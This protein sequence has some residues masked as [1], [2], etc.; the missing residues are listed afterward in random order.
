MSDFAV[1]A[2]GGARLGLL[3]C[4]DSIQWLEHYADA[5]EVKAVAQATPQNIELT[6]PGNRIY[7]PE[8]G[9][10][11]TIVAQKIEDTGRSASV[12]VR[13]VTGAGRLQDRVNM[14]TIRAADAQTAMRSTVENN[15]RGLPMDMEPPRD[16]AVKI[17]TQAS[18]GT[19]LDALKSFAK[20]SGLG[21]GCS[22]D[23]STGREAFGVR[24]GVDRTQGAAYNGYFGDDI[25]NIS[26]I[27]LARSTSD[28]KNVAV[29]AGQGKGAAR[30]LVVVH[31]L[32]VGAGDDRRELWVDAKD[33]QTSYQVAVD[34]GQTDAGGSPVYEYRTVQYTPEEYQSI[35]TARGLEKLAEHGT[36][37]T[38]DCQA[39][40]GGTLTYGV[41]Y[42]LGDVLPI[43][44]TRYGV[45]AVARVTGI[46]L[47]YEAG[48]RQ[49]QPILSDF[50][51]KA[52]KAAFDAEMR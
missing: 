14:G 40:D 42:G 17:N 47:I 35:L 6:Q 34:T 10:A 45:M 15:L 19:V 23:P 28:H 13:A 18:W 36:E 30:T 12:T 43:K 16:V 2:P 52:A 33:I 5:G 21:F 4:W 20:A 9:T 22:F 8:T 27:R 38:L 25:A 31:G 11:A 3:E 48:G 50:N 51:V 32:F 29:V 39:Q 26:D 49:V 7:N 44:I 24:L 1:Y 46:R 37:L 41:D